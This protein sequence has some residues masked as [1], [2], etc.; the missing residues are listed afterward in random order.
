MNKFT[1]W[2]VLLCF[3][4]MIMH[5]SELDK[6]SSYSSDISN[7]PIKQLFSPSSTQSPTTSAATP[8]KAS[9]FQI[10]STSSSKKQQ[11]TQY[12]NL[13]N[14]CQIYE[15]CMYYLNNDDNR[16]VIASLEC[17]QVLI[18]LVPLKFSLYLTRMCSI[19]ANCSVVSFLSINHPNTADAQQQHQQNLMTSSMLSLSLSNKLSNSLDSLTT[20]KPSATQYSLVQ[21]SGDL[22]HPLQ[23]TPL[24]ADNRSETGRSINDENVVNGGVY[25]PVKTPSKSIGTFYD[26]NREPIVYLVRYLAYKYLLNANYTAAQPAGE[27][28]KSDAEVKVLVKAVAL[29]CCS[30]CISLCPHLVFKTLF[31]SSEL[32]S[33]AQLARLYIYD[34]IN[35]INH[36][37]DKMRTTTCV[38]VGQFINT[39]LI[40]YNGNYDSWLVDMTNKYMPQ[41]SP[42]QPP[43]DASNVNEQKTLP[44]STSCRLQI[45]ILVDYLMRFIR[46]ENPKLTNNLCKRFAV[47]ALHSFVPTLVRTKYSTFALDIIINILHLKHST[48]NLVKC[49]LV[50]LL[51]SIDF[52]AIN[53]TEQVRLNS[54]RL[55]HVNSY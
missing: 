43:S 6:S 14:L 2:G 28:L 15:I 44:S 8:T 38:L 45:E 7:I 20:L 21:E 22:K 9:K 42:P 33:N 55:Y 5:L 46:L 36:S 12:F 1:I 34:L 18:K 50:D 53:Y 26:S 24:T 29:D 3:R 16:I 31:T 52:K 19:S 11:N 25:R 48:Y 40:E 30:S 47:S 13:I 10:H 4:Y 49:E 41:V 23:Q 51:A 39:V 37:D 17:L 27:R 32:K 54:I 35:Y